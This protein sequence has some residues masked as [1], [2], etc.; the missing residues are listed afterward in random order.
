MDPLQVLLIVESQNGRDQ[1]HVGLVSFLAIRTDELMK[2][3][4]HP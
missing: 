3:A 1:S 2:M 4:Q